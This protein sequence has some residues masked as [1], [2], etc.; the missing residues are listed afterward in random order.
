MSQPE[1]KLSRQIQAA[2]RK[3]GAFCFKVHGSEYMMSGLPD[4][5]VCYEGV[6]IGLE[7]KT[8]EGKEPTRR[9]LYVHGNIRAAYG[10][11]HVV[12]SVDGALAV[13]DGVDEW[14]A[15]SA[16]AE[17]NSAIDTHGPFSG[18]Q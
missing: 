12:R 7:T 13:L 3:R 5:I 15:D 16:A 11:V 9:Q 2:L 18:M 8:P 4:I 1:S 6:F 14:L 17:I 10:H